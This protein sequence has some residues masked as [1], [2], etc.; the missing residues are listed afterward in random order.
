MLELACTGVV[1]ADWVGLQKFCEA[2]VKHIITNNS[3][4]LELNYIKK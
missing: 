3:Y 1:E 2:A 4:K